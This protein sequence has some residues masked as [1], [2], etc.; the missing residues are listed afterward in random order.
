MLGLRDCFAA[1][2]WAS[3]FAPQHWGLALLAHCSHLA[4]I[5]LHVAL[6]AALRVD[7]AICS[8]SA[9]CFRN[10]SY[11]YIEIQRSVLPRSRSDRNTGS[12]DVRLSLMHK[13]PPN[14]GLVNTA[15]GAAGPTKTNAVPVTR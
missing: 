13:R 3:D 12:C 10:S 4:A 15:L 9:A 8:H 6:L 5:S 2:G 7:L 11:A 14:S 1:A